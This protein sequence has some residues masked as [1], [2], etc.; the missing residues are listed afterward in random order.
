MAY[1]STL[2]G[3][4]IRL[5]SRGITFC[6]QTKEQKLSKSSGPGFPPPR[7]L[8]RVALAVWDRHAERIWREGRWPAVDTELL[9]VFAETIDLYLRFKADVDRHGT[10]VPGR[11]D[12]ELVRNP[13]LMGLGQ[14]R[15]DLVRLARQIPL[16]APR[17]AGADSGADIDRFLA[18]VMG[19]DQ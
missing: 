18:D 10:L 2:P 8:D 17:V 3:Q 15:A 4:F 12:S 14:C 16:T 19:D 11:T 1:A 13:S 7:P 6:Q 5:T 9:A